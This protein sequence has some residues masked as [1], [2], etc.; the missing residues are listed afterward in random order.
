MIRFSVHVH[1]GSQHDDVGG[2]YDGALVVHVRG[3]A[4]K[5]LATRG[6]LSS[7]AGAFSVPPSAVTLV[8]GAM[9]RTKVVDIHGNDAQLQGRLNELLER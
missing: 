6:V 5:G 1:P 9:S 7:L 8:R 2:S 4:V 3:R